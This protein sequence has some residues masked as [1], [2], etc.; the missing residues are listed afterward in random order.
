M[1][2]LV[3]LVVFIALLFGIVAALWPS[4]S[5][6][7]EPDGLDRMIESIQSQG[8]VGVLILLGLQLLQIVV[9]FIPGEVVQVA[10]GMLYGPLFGTLI[11]LLGCVISSSLIYMLVH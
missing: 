5:M 9:A 10:A 1:F 4:F 7:F 6:L 11:I 3:G 8:P 2:K